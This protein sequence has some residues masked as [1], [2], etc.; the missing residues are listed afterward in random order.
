MSVWS[1]PYL[2]SGEVRTSSFIRLAVSVPYLIV[3]VRSG[4]FPHSPCRVSSLPD[5]PCRVSSGNLLIRLAVSAQVSSLIRFAI[6]IFIV[7]IHFTVPENY[8]VYWMLEDFNVGEDV[9]R[10]FNGRPSVRGRVVELNELHLAVFI[11]TDGRTMGFD[12]E[13]IVGCICYDRP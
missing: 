1:V 3:S 12:L 13:D 7:M 10:I 2:R 8:T 5:S 4:Q 11:K 6:S 9:R